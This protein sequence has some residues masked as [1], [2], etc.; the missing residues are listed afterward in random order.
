M[1][2]PAHEL[3]ILSAAKL[4]ERAIWRLVAPNTLRGGEHRV[5]SITLLIVTIILIA[6]NDYFIS[7]LPSTNF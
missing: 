1:F 5:S 3:P 4:R 7:D 6:V 2:R